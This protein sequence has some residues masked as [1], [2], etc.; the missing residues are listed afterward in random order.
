MSLLLA[1][2]VEKAPFSERTKFS[3]GAGELIRKSC[4]G[5]PNQSGFQPVVF[6]SSLQ[7]HGL[8][9]LDLNG[10]IAKFC[11]WLVSDFFNRIGQKQTFC[12]V[13]RDGCELNKLPSRLLLYRRTTM[14]IEK[15]VLREDFRA[16]MK[17]PAIGLPEYSA[18]LQ[19]QRRVGRMIANCRAGDVSHARRELVVNSIQTR[20]PEEP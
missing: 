6:C 7:S 11:R 8:P 17:S 20:L 3:G 4:G 2:S 15:D 12:L 18:D 9:R 5:S 19:V 16:L 10:R 1:N 13:Q 14:T